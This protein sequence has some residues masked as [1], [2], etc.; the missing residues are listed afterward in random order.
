M[1]IIIPR[2]SLTL[3]DKKTASFFEKKGIDLKDIFV[4]RHELEKLLSHELEDKKVNEK[5]E[6]MKS[7]LSKAI[8]PIA[9]NAGAY[10]ESILRSVEASAHKIMKEAEGIEKRIKA[11]VIAKKQEEKD[12]YF[13]AWAMAYPNTS[14]QERIYSPLTFLNIIGRDEFENAIME[15]ARK[16]MEE[17]QE[18]KHRIIRL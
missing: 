15:Q 16:H 8:K 18:P 12:K 6:E 3:F 14:L 11:A 13:H 4:E 10:S 2:L 1:P 9:D 7:E 17:L 5:L